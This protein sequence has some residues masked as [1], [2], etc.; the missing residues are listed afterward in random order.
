MESQ[1]REMRIIISGGGT[2]GHVFPAIA[3]ANALKKI[4]PSVNIL[5]VGAEG[6]M[7]MEKVPAAGY[8]IIGLKISG[9][10]RRLTWRN[11]SFPFKVFA[12]LRK[13]KKII[14]DFKPDVV[15]GVGGY[16]SG[17][18]VKA[19][20]RLRIPAVLQEQNSY[21]GITNK[22]LA[23]KASKICV[24]Y[25][26]LEKYFPKEKIFFTGNPVRQ[27]IV[28]LTRK[29]ERG[30]EEFGFDSTKPVVLVVGGSLGARTINESIHAGLERIV[31][32]GIQLIWQTG[33]SYASLANEASKPYLERG[34][35]TFDFITRM[36][37]AYAAADIVVSRAGAISISELCL[38]KKPAIL[39]P[40][41]NV[42]E[43]HQTHNAMAL[44]NY[45]AAV[46]VKD[47]E[48]KES[49]L[50]VLMDLIKDKEKCQQLER[51]IAGLGRSD[52]A[53]SIANIIIDLANEKK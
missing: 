42:A 20:S 28:N 4:F 27:D 36:D 51:N 8:K 25:D 2:G 13:A 52:A 5:F 41:P 49:L 1:P 43:D 47:A 30:Y 3:I 44:V 29:R 18:L 6:R 35:K 46:M 31:E 17:P 40:S 22:L 12:A 11:L 53:D 9:F 33:K 39:V 10:Q 14:K 19:A 34:L 38:V 16:A 50:N 21:P 23:P 37:L 45:Q 15:V 32:N 48:A 24:A 7:E 26:G